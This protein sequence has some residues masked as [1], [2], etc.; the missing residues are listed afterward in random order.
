[1]SSTPTDYLISDALDVGVVIDGRYEITGM[2]GEGGSAEVYRARQL[3][4]NREV[5][6]KILHAPTTSKAA[7]RYAERF[8]REARV[9]AQIEHPGIVAV[10]DYGVFDG[11][12]PYIVLELLKGRSL[13]EELVEEIPLA[14]ALDL[15][16]SALQALNA[17]HK[18]N[19][20]HRDLKPGNLFLTTDEN[21]NERLKVL[22]FGLAFPTE[23]VQERLTQ[24]G[25]VNGTPQYVSPEYL[26]RQIVTPALDVYQMGLIF[27]E[28]LTGK[29]VIDED[30]PYACF[31]IHC[32]GILPIPRWVRQTCVGHI[33]D[34]AT[35]LDHT[36]RYQ[37]AAEFLAALET[38]DDEDISQLRA[39]QSERGHEEASTLT[40]AP[41]P[42]VPAAEELPLPSAV[43][44]PPPSL[45]E[46]M[47]PI[48]GM[49]FP[50]YRR[51]VLIAA[52]AAFALVFVGVMVT[53]VVSLAGGDATN[54]TLPEAVTLDEID[55]T[56]APEVEPAPVIEPSEVEISVHPA[57]AKV[58][59]GDSLLGRGTATVTFGPDDPDVVELRVESPGYQT[60][61]LKVDRGAE[62]VSIK[63]R[64]NRRA[65]NG[66]ARPKPKASPKPKKTPKKPLKGK[67]GEVGFFE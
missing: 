34:R 35:H 32:S 45:R 17:A 44:A 21:G 60:Q 64:H 40:P 5:A 27:V 42:P 54:E 11:R 61:T 58:F 55:V 43:P 37:D 2:I 4:I 30:S 3:N 47:P 1:M 8:L 15:M 33:V 28:M 66:N 62:P 39:T 41:T 53:F 48:M 19:I 24:A 12:Q 22:D 67:T 36:Q 49:D 6:L 14:R 52:A 38:L 16:K 20:V 10:Y 29:P 23:Q 13:E 25:H 9:V 7:R 56:P 65:S 26:E 57:R 50:E 63:L 51:V 31:V 59:V 18:L 46:S